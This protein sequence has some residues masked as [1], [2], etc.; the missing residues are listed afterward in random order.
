MKPHFFALYLTLFLTFA[1][2]S[3]QT[4][5][6]Q[7]YSVTVLAD[8]LFNANGQV[9]SIDIRDEKQYPQEFLNKVLERLQKAKIPPVI[10]DGQAKTFRT[11][12]FATLLIT[13]ND[14][15]G[16]VS[17]KSLRIEPL[18]LKTYAASYPKDLVMSPGWEGTVTASCDVGVDGKCHAIQLDAL[19][20]VPDSARRFV[21]TSLEG[22]QFQPQQVDGKPV[23]GRAS[24]VFNM[25]SADFAPL[26]FRIPKFDRIL[27][28]R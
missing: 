25:E 6:P 2:T 21:K 19:P 1:D 15:G 18:V 12:V 17:F 11:G 13:P 14:S 16:S 26:D 10:E 23:P 24:V 4:V 22:W 3:A 28:S 20:G 9:A 7:A 8:V 5:S 27:Q